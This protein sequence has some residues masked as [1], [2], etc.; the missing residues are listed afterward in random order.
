M[1]E[2]SDR[3]FMNMYNELIKYVQGNMPQVYSR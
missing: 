2:L 1:E 3:E